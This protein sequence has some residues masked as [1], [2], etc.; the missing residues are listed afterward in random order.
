MCECVD[1][2][3][4]GRHAC[5]LFPFHIMMLMWIFILFCFF[6]LPPLPIYSRKNEMAHLRAAA[7]LRVPQLCP[8]DGRLLSQRK[9]M[10]RKLNRYVNVQSLRSPHKSA[11]EAKTQN[12]LQ[13]K[14]KT[15]S[16]TTQVYN[17]VSVCMFQW[18]CVIQKYILKYPV[19][20]II[21]IRPKYILFI[22]FFF[23]SSSSSLNSKNPFACL[24]KTT[25]SDLEV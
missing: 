21:D 2:C 18:V 24:V 11:N 22:V 9:W 8:T 1:V 12:Y 14:Q 25:I 20:P 16:Y 3:V 23:S 17:C 15:N 13:E 19:L 5:M 4:G 7:N 6:S 10:D